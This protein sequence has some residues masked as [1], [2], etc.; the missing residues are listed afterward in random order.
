[1]NAE[2]VVVLDGTTGL[3]PA[4]A[5]V[6]EAL[7]DVLRGRSAGV[8]TF[9]LRDE[10]IAHCIGCFGCWVETP[11]LCRSADRGRD[12]VGNMV[13]ADTVVLVTPVTFGGYSSILKR[14]VDKWIQVLLP[15]FETFH[16]ELH[17]PLRYGR[18]PRLLAVGIQPSPDPGEATLFRSLVARNALNFRTPSHAAELFTGSETAAEL[19][20]RLASL[21]ERCDPMP[22]PDA[23]AALV[24][25]PPAWPDAKSAAE[26]R[27]ALVLVGSPKTK[28]PSTSGVL[29]RHLLA[30]LEKRGWQGEALTITAA[31][32]SETWRA[33]M[34]A[35]VD[36]AD[37]L[38]L[39]FPLYID[40]LPA[41]LTRALEV[42]RDDRRGRD[43]GRNQRLVAVV[44][45]GF[46]E[47]R[48][49]RLA[50]AMCANFAS[51]AGFSWAGGLAMGAGEALSSGVP[52]TERAPG[53]AR[54]PVG[55]VVAALDRA[56]GELAEG[57]PL[58]PAT[59]ALL[60][61]TPIPLLPSPVWRRLFAFM[62]G[63]GWKRQAA[64]NGV[65]PGGLLARPFASDGP[66]RDTAPV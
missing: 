56:A 36:A 66:H 62:G 44:N 19:R 37:L 28:K 22:A 11:G 60:A 8:D 41:L 9:A 45:S 7:G 15:F 52:L 43:A 35:A 2:R 54:P 65:G 16:G 21:L 20:G 33:K 55:H 3:D 25:E 18:F 39:A 46:P 48:Q 61:R 10:R 63:Q 42:I 27:T 51:A 57:R 50:L 17:H 49:N 5:R 31:I 59:R 34:L 53:R 6:G 13:R 58:S 26:G 23:L 14:L 29:G 4:E 64:G 12:I 1:M 30:R 32:R 47:A 24:P 40:A 38:I